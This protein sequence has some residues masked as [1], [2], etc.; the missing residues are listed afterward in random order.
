MVYRG[1]K[2][3]CYLGI[4]SYVEGVPPEFL[5]SK[6]VSPAAWKDRM[7][8]LSTAQIMSSKSSKRGM[9]VGS[10]AMTVAQTASALTNQSGGTIGFTYE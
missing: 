4:Q 1:T 9:L 6:G 8:G 2:Y 3:L 10:N 7:S 5:R